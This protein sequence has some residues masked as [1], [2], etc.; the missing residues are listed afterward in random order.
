[1]KF[2]KNFFTGRFRLLLEVT[3]I[4]VVSKSLLRINCHLKEMGLQCTQQLNMEMFILI[5]AT[6]GDHFS[7]Q[8]TS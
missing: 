4:V 5:E 3:E 7:N 8:A 2:A 6:V 1:M